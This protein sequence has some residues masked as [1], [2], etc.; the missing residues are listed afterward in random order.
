MT[1]KKKED[2]EEGIVILIKPHTKG[3]FAVG[4]TTNYIADT[5]EKEMCK[6]VAL[7]A[8][9]LMLEDPDPFYERGIEIAAQTDDMDASKTEEFITKDDESNILDLTKY[10]DKS[11][12]N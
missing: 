11:K 6:L 12:L 1:K 10:I 7:G 5:P 4:I 8:A 2:V 3:K 9:Q